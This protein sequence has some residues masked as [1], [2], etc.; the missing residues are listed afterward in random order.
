MTWKIGKAVILV[1]QFMGDTMAL[2]LFSASERS[3]FV[4]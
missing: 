3:A 4:L 2:Y 1:G